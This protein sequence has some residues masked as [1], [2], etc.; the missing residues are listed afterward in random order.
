MPCRMFSSTPALYTLDAKSTPLPQVV[1][2]KDISRL[3]NVLGRGGAREQKSHLLENHD[4]RA[5]LVACC[6][7]QKDLN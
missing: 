5:G 6:G 7:S 4:F 3:P 2:D 1:A